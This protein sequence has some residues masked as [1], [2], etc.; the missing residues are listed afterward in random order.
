MAGRLVGVQSGPEESIIAALQCLYTA[1]IPSLKAKQ[2]NKGM[3][4]E[5]SP[6]KALAREV[7]MAGEL[8][9]CVAWDRRHRLFAGQKIMVR[10]RL[11]G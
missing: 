2:R 3:S 4:S 1:K 8:Q 11:V 7:A 9:I 6:N 5:L 10:F